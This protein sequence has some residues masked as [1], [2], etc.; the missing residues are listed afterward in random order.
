MEHNAIQ[1]NLMFTRRE[2][3]HAALQ[4]HLHYTVHDAA[5]VAHHPS[6]TR[7]PT[8]LEPA[9]DGNAFLFR[10]RLDTKDSYL[11]SS[12]LYHVKDSNSQHSHVAEPVELFMG[13][14]GASRLEY[15][16]KVFLRNFKLQLL[17]QQCLERDYK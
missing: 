6:V 8:P 11:V 7:V 12:S 5:L 14:R 15:L 1:N 17:S 4:F 10:L 9:G 3:L 16:Q 2:T 13:D